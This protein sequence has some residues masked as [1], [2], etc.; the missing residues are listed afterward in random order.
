MNRQQRR[1]A[2]KATSGRDAALDGE[3]SRMLTERPGLVREIMEDLEH[4]GLIY[5]TG[6]RRNGQIVY[7]ATPRGK[8]RN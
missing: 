5:D 7:A 2:K 8:E 1:A 3:I 6:R 4:E